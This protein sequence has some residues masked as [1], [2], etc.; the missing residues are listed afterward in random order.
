M[1]KGEERMDDRERK[2]GARRWEESLRRAPMQRQAV[3]RAQDWRSHLQRS[4]RL[5]V[6]S[7]S[8]AA[9][10]AAASASIG[11]RSRVRETHRKA[12]EASFAAVKYVNGNSFAA[13]ALRR[14]SVHCPSVGAWQVTHFVRTCT[15]VRADDDAAA[16]HPRAQKL[17]PERLLV[18]LVNARGVDAREQPDAAVRGQAHCADILLR[19]DL[20]DRDDLRVHAAQHHR[21]A[22]GLW[23]EREHVR[24]VAELHLR[25]PLAAHG[26]LAALVDDRHAQRAVFGIPE[27]QHADEVTQQRRFPAAGRREN[28]RAQKTARQR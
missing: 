14:G 2:P 17:P 18:Q 23:A 21:D 8:A 16:K 11:R 1:K 19:R 7:S 5:L 15:A 12:R 6:R 28:E 3:R 24:V 27:R 26:E 9:A 10:R 4:P 22:G 13:T 20:I 25:S